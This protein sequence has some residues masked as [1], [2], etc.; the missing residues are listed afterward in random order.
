MGVGR[1]SGGANKFVLSSLQSSK[2]VTALLAGNHEELTYY[3]LLQEGECWAWEQ[4]VHCP[5]NTGPLTWA[6]PGRVRH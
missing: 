6:N 4:R 1:H 5:M 2:Q 3:C